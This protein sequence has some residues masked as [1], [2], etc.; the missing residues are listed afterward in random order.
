VLRELGQAGSLLCSLLS[1]Y[2]LMDAAFFVQGTRW[3]E[4]LAMSLVRILLAAVVCFASGWMFRYAAR[5][6]VALLRTLPVRLF[7]W[8]LPAFALLFVLS[9]YL[10]V[11][12]VPLI[13]KN[14]PY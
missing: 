5:P 11:Y 4:R 10:S 14:Q 8:A 7:L 6:R 3:E 13:W 12:Y 9:W 2:A 1:L